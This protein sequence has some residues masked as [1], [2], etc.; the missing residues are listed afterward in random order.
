MVK[1]VI[2]LEAKTGTATKDIKNLGQEI[3]SLNS[4]LV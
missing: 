4:D 2:E 1:K 3:Q